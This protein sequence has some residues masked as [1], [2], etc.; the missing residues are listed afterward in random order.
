MRASHLNYSTWA[1]DYSSGYGRY[2]WHGT[3]QPP[4]TSPAPAPAPQASDDNLPA[5]GAG[6]FRAVQEVAAGGLGP[7]K[8]LKLNPLAGTGSDPLDNAVGTRIADFKPIST[9]PLT[10]P[11]T[12]GAAL[13]ELPLV[14]PATGL[15]PG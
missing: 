6:V 12:Q 1:S 15:L 3:Q 13:G 11:L 2:P 8:H 10:A 7:A 9:A 14:G 4:R 5:A